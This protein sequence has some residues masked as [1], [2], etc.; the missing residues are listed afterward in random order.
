MTVFT[1]PVDADALPIQ[2]VALADNRSTVSISGSSSA[3][4]LPSGVTAGRIIRLAL[5]TDSYIR[6]G[7]GATTVSSSTGHLFP[8]G[9]EVLVVPKDCTHVAFIAADGSSTGAGTISEVRT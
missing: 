6:F 4:A 8:A 9:V 2:A 7:T 5:D 3:V 1:L